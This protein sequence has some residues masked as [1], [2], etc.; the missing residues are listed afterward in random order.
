MIV[1]RTWTALRL[2]PES[3]WLTHLT[4]WHLQLFLIFNIVIPNTN[5][6]HYI[7]SESLWLWERVYLYWFV[8][9]YFVTAYSRIGSV[10]NSGERLWFWERILQSF[11]LLNL[12]CARSRF[13]NGVIVLNTFSSGHQ[14]CTWMLYQKIIIDILNIKWK[15]LVR[16]RVITWLKQISFL[17]T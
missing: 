4:Q 16:A 2:L 5:S 1:T 9:L 8:G 3:L 6:T 11:L 12:I 17:F 13:I 15:Y 10:G 14:C 7:F